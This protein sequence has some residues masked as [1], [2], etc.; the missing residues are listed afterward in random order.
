MS[1]PNDALF[2]HPHGEQT[3]LDTSTGKG[4]D[5]PTRKKPTKAELRAAQNAARDAELIASLDQPQECA[6]ATSF[7]VRDELQHLLERDLLGPWD[8]PTEELPLRYS[9]PRE[10]YLVGMLGPRH[11]PP[12]STRDAADQM[13][14]S[15]AGADGAASG[16]D[17]GEVTEKSTTQNLG[18]M[19]ASTMGLSFSVPADTD[20][21]HVRA[22]WGEYGRELVEEDEGKKRNVWVREPKEHEVEVRLAGK[23]DD[24]LG[25]TDPDPDTSCVY[26]AVSVREDRDG[27]PRCTVEL[28]LVN[29][30]VPVQPNGDS[31][32]LFQPELSVTALDGAAPVFLPV[33]APLTDTAPASDDP[34]ELHLRLLYRDL[35]KYADG[36]NIAVS[37]EVA[38]GARRAHRLV[39]TWLPHH[40]VPAT[41]AAVGEGSAL[42]SA[43]LS[44]DV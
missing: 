25:L 36:R 40:D 22:T 39:T 32:W 23:P 18:H 28:T 16:E 19:W 30:R 35:L 41:T 3:T 12:L 10:R 1:E 9:G 5:S 33:D 14:E 37:A 42:A 43:Q 21:V 2:E 29:N 27:L 8:G 34:E 6:E 44:M 17:A 31:M 38:E 20:A 15:E 4:T 26:L 7:Q 24:K 11:Q 13:E